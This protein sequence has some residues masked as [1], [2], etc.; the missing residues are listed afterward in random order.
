MIDDVGRELAGG[1]LG[2]HPGNELPAGSPHHL[3][4]HEREALVEGL[5]HLG[6]D[7]GEIGCVVDDLAFLLRSLDQLVAAVG[8][9][10]GRLAADCRGGGGR[11]E[12][13]GEMPAID[14][15]VCH[16]RSP[17]L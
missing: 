13:G 5:D 16:E 6:L 12:A 2:F 4:L 17:F 8:L 9:R 10:V 11:R 1:R 3:D 15:K 14:A 7:L